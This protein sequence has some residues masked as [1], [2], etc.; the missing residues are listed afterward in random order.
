ML[1]ISPIIFFKKR[2]D[3]VIYVKNHSILFIYT[4]NCEKYLVTGNQAR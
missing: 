1:A 4:N 2:M 3:F